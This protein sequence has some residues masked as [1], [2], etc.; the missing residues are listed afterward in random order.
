LK[1][2]KP[3]PRL[4][5]GELPPD[6]PEP[7]PPYKVPTL[8]EEYRVLAIVFGVLALALAVYFVKSIITAP[9]KPPPAQQAVYIETVAPS[10]PV[11]EPVAPSA[12]AKP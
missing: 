4:F 6:Y 7:L 1:K 9:P 3:A 10:A 5:R 8:L 11:K 12:P 2:L